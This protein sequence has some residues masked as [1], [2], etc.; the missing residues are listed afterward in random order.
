MVNPGEICQWSGRQAT[1]YHPDIAKNQEQQNQNQ[2]A[3]QQGKGNAWQSGQ[4]DLWE[5]YNKGKGE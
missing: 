4:P 5:A 1:K 3:N 2:M